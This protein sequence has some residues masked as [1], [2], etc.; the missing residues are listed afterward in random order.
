MAETNIKEA[1]KKFWNFVWK[2]DS[3]WSWIVSLILAFIIVKFI[4]FPLLSLALG[5]SLPLVVVESGS[6]HHPGTFLG[7]WFGTQGSFDSWWNQQGAWYLDRGFTKS[8]IESWSMRTGME[9]GDIIVVYG[10]GT[11]HIGDIIIFNANTQYP[12]IHRVINITEIN[13]QIF[14]STK[15]DNNPGQLSI[16]QQI[17][18]SAILGKASFK[19]PKLGWIKLAFAGIFQR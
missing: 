8:Q 12:I 17:P 2:D 16:E 18:S 10:R 13:G 3:I 11:V 5:S 7:N 15:G 14:Y 19:I 1:L 6:M 9:K 4:F